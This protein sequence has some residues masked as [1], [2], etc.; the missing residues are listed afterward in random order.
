MWGLLLGANKSV[1]AMALIHE[2]GTVIT[3]RYLPALN[4]MAPA[5]RGD[6]SND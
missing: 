3:I 1:M 5:N 2:R 4:I 6:A